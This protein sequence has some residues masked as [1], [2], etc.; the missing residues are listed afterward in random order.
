MARPRGTLRCIW[1]HGTYLKDRFKPGQ[2]LALYGKVEQ[3]RS[4]ALQLIQP[5]FEVLSEAAGEN[6]GAALDQSLEIGRIVPVYESAASGKLTTRWFRHAI[7]R[8]L[9]QL[10]PEVPDALPTAIQARLGLPPRRDAICKTHWPDAGESTAQ[11]QEFRTPAQ[12]RLIFEELFFLELGLGL[13]RKRLRAQPGISFEI[14]DHVRAAVKRILP[15]HP[16]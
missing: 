10:T 4:G 5:Q 2:V 6:G 7:H 3:D 13:K 16:T 11:L 9:E 15:F 1:F 14:T 8:T 12:R